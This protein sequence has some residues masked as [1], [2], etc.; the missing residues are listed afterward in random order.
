MTTSSIK[1]VVGNAFGFHD[2]ALAIIDAYGNVRF[3]QQTE[4]VTG[5]KHDKSAHPD[6]YFWLE[7]PNAFYEKPYWRIS[8]QWFSG[9]EI[10]G[11]QHGFD[12]YIEHHWAH[13]A[14]SY[15]TRPK[16]WNTEPVCVVIDA[17][18]EWDTS[19]IW[20]KGKKVWSMQYP[21]S[22]GL[23]YSAITE[24]IGFQPNRD[25]HLTMALAGT[26]KNLD[27]ELYQA[28]RDSITSK[29]FHIGVNIELRKMIEKISK[30]RVAYVAQLV[31]ENEI[32][33][34]MKIARKYSPYLCYGG[35][36]ALNCVANTLVHQEFEDTW[37]FP[38]PGD[39]GAAFGAAAAVLKTHIP[40]EHNFWGK[41]IDRQPNPKEIA[42]NIYEQQVAGLVNGRDEFGPRALGNR[43]LLA[44]P[45]GDL[46]ADHIYKIKN[47]AKWSP[48][49]P[50]ILEEH[51]EEYFTGP[52]SRYMSYVSHLNKSKLHVGR[53][54]H[55]DGTSRVQ[56]VPPDS[57]SLLRNV[58]EEW[59]ELTACPLLINTSLNNKGEPVP[60]HI[61]QAIN[62]G[63][64]HGITVF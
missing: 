56:V 28:F 17:V 7:Y 16:H 1:F 10:R 27:I 42:R 5:I 63:K 60:G 3:A 8:R 51:F 11:K 32:L 19:S 53:V 9:E 61:A 38:N 6:R 47:R 37:I 40:M 58:L 21:I 4:R 34:I 43:S 54:A 52:K 13:A 39:A 59:Y 18:G 36:V 24:A 29:G 50:A 30:G 33:K 15:Y 14:A 31:L 25:E 55:D 57:P 26:Y 48:L 2:G 44:D 45:R 20:Y 62:F 12:K 64:T 23:F 46:G 22:L 49:A 35:G 41:L